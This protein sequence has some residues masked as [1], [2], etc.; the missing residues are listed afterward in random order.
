MRIIVQFEN[1]FPEIDAR[2]NDSLDFPNKELAEKWIRAV[3]AKPL[4][5][6]SMGKRFVQNARILD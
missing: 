4:K 6:V 2:Q 1:Y 5:T 3:S